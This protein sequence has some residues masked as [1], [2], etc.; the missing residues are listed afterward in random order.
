M[1]FVVGSASCGCAAVAGLLLQTHGRR[2]FFFMEACSE[3]FQGAATAAAALAG[4]AA[5][6]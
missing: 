3:A 4:M 6:M 1:R 5:I 2:A